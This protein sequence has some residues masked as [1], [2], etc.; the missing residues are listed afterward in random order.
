MTNTLNVI[1][2]PYGK[3]IEDEQS[4]FKKDIL[5]GLSSP[6]KEIYSKYFYDQEGSRLFNK[7]TRHPDYYL[8]NCEIEILQS[9]K[10]KISGILHKEVFNLIEL[11]P[12]ECIKTQLL[13]QQFLQDLLTFT[14]TPI[15]ISKIY[16][17]KIVKEFQIQLPSL[18]INAIN[19]DYFQALEWLNVESEKRNFVLFLG[20]SI[21]NLDFTAAKAF[22]RHLW[23]V[24]HP[25]DLVLIGFDLKKDI[26]IL[27]RAYND[28]DGITQKFNLNLLHRI[29][30]ELGS[31]FCIDKFTH[32]GTYNANMGAMESYIISQI[33]QE[34]KIHDLN[35]SF[36]FHA[37]E[38]IH[39]EYSF[40]Y[41][42]S[43]VE[44]LANTTGFSVVDHFL[45]SQH[46]FVDSLWQVKK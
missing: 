33:D 2:Q 25:N 10:K 38:P 45:D 8:T 30:R 22:L 1:T 35:Q 5:K 29:N 24:L 43:Q 18:E 9:Y 37:F 13:I 7:I 26:D 21:G 40:K 27:L 11:G 32:Y 15:D 42:L 41:L 46:Y 23:D 31:N 34:V 4:E 19:S 14:Y 44:G 6:C 12:G 36:Y 39:V 17:E 3:T 20:S 16:L 28:S